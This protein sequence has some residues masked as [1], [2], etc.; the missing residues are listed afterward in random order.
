MD[1]SYW[2][3]KNWKNSSFPSLVCLLELVHFKAAGGGNDCDVSRVVFASE[4]CMRGGDD[5][6][7]SGCRIEQR[8]IAEGK[9]YPET[10]C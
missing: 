6:G 9:K 7:N 3:F 5:C 4:S 2:A 8:V 10:R 1:F